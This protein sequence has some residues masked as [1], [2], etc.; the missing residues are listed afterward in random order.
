MLFVIA[1]MLV[2]PESGQVQ[3][4][5]FRAEFYVQQISLFSSVC[6]VLHISFHDDYVPDIYSGHGANDSGRESGCQ[7]LK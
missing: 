7:K 5:L 6:T 1:I 3:G 2:L 4:V